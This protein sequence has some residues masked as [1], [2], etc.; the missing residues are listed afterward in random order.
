MTRDL[1][2]VCDRRWWWSSTS[3]YRRW[4][5]WRLSS[6]HLSLFRWSS[7]NWQGE[8]TVVGV[9]DIVW[10]QVMYNRWVEAGNK[11]VEISKYQRDALDLKVVGSSRAVQ[12]L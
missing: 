12:L 7:S 10:G 4:R 1:V 9:G 2:R 11:L 3:S 6:R 8:G 5:G